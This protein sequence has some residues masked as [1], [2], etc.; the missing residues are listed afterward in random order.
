MGGCCWMLCPTADTLQLE[1][2]Q[3]EQ[4]HLLLLVLIFGCPYTVCVFTFVNV[5][6]CTAGKCIIPYVEYKQRHQLCLLG[7]QLFFSKLIC[8]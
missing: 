8:H 7:C 3:H 6:A 4:L 1:M 5:W 2:R